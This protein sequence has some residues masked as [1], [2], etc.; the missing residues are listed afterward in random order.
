MHPI[1]YAGSGTYGTP[2]SKLDIT[3]LEDVFANMA[4]FQSL[5]QSLQREA[6][7][8]EPQT[9]R[10]PSPSSNL[11]VLKPPPSKERPSSP[12]SHASKILTALSE[13]LSEV[14]TTP[15]PAPQAE[16]SKQK[17]KQPEA[18]QAHQQTFLDRIKQNV[19]DLATKA[20]RYVES[21]ARSVATKVEQIGAALGIPPEFTHRCLAAV[22]GFWTTCKS[23]V[24]KLWDAAV[25]SVSKSTRSSQAET[26]SPFEALQN[27]SNGKHPFIETP[28]SSAG[29]EINLGW[30]YALLRPQDSSPSIGQKIAEAVENYANGVR[31]KE[32]EDKQVEEQD[33]KREKAKDD[34]K[35]ERV[36]SLRPDLA[37]NPVIDRLIK[38][39]GITVNEAF[40]PT[41]REIINEAERSVSY[42]NRNKQR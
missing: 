3:S 8:G 21:A 25:E 15:K 10:A 22:S 26:I 36:L 32:K 28:T 19:S 1:I 6:P 18:E 9:S 39:P 41:E 2:P 4:N 37:D 33:Q 34:K 29:R 38:E 31:K 30:G 7:K 16:R 11:N 24:K 14:Q 13:N 5:N 27:D 42:T 17:E 20:T 35:I 40:E 23:A 12:T